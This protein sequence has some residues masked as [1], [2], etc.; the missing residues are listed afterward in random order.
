MTDPTP[1][2]P[3]TPTTPAAAASRTRRLLAVGAGLV[4]FFVAGAATVWALAP[5][6]ESAANAATDTTATTDADHGGEHDGEHDA[7][8]DGEHDADHDSEHDAECDIP[9]ESHAGDS[10]HGHTLHDSTDGRAVTEED[11]ANAEAFYDEVRTTAT[12]LYADLAAAEAAGYRIS[13]TSARSPNPLDHYQLAGGND[14]QLDATRPEGL[15]YWTDPDTGE[16]LLVG[17][18]FLETGDDLPQPGGPLTVWHDHHDPETCLEVDPDCNLEEGAANAPRML[19]VWFFEGVHD[20]FA[21]DFPGAVGEQGPG[22][23]GPLPWER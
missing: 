10:D 8:H 21:H 12:A 1:T 4:A 9:V 19:H 11:C 15:I 3:A 6:G 14:A 16:S 2:L 17:V 5:G 7:D 20:V 18:V 13:G 23:D 22:R